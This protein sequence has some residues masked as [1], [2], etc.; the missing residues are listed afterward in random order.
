MRLQAQIA[1]AEN[2]LK[3]G[4]ISL[5]TRLKKMTQLQ[6]RLKQIM[7]TETNQA[8]RVLLKQL[9][10]EAEGRLPN[11]QQTGDIIMDESIRHG[12]WMAKKLNLMKITSRKVR[13]IK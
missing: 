2:S 8:A 10:E 12:S 4:E 5:V 3:K 13:E 9:I 11:R 6:D 7:D 1:T